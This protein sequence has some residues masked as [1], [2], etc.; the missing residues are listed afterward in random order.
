MLYRYL[1]WGNTWIIN[2]EPCY[3]MMYAVFPHF[4]ASECI[5]A[6][7]SWRHRDIYD[8]LGDPHPPSVLTG[9][10]RHR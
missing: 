7:S 4:L 2:P 10:A 3:R 5:N 6:D 8:R 1:L 9:T